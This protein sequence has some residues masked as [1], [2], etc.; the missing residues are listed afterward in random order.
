MLIYYC[1][2]NSVL[3]LLFLRVNVTRV[4]FYCPQLKAWRI[5]YG[6]NSILLYACRVHMNS[7]LIYYVERV[8]MYETYGNNI[9]CHTISTTS[10][11]LSLRYSTMLFQLLSVR[12]DQGDPGPYR[13]TR[14]NATHAFAIWYDTP[15]TPARQGIKRKRCNCKGKLLRRG[16]QDRTYVCVPKYRNV[17]YNTM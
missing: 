15:W 1:I 10:C 9:T 13:I 14:P 4:G 12:V 2:H 8:C 11:M 5:P 7:T 17:L 16:P 6:P 3:T